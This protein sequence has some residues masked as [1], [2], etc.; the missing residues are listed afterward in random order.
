MP[1]QYAP[2]R[3]YESGP[4]HDR[5]PARHEN[6]QIERIANPTEQTAHIQ[7][8]L[9]QPKSQKPQQPHKTPLRARMH[10]GHVE[11]YDGPAE[12]RNPTAQ[13]TLKQPGPVRAGSEPR[14][15][16][17]G[18][19][20]KPAVRSGTLNPAS[21]KVAVP[22][23][24]RSQAPPMKHQMSQSTDASGQERG[25]ADKAQSR[26]TRMGHTQVRPGFPLADSRG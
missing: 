22:D 26:N 15:P 16:A 7:L 12:R 21:L 25:R 2:Q 18:V 23:T 3:I 24:L 11:G 1:L 5:S 13:S 6:E 4:P 9:G 14:R 10:A 19:A 20:A 8:P 17:D